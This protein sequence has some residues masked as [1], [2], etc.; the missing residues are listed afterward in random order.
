MCCLSVGIEEVHTLV[1]HNSLHIA[2]YNIFYYMHRNNST[3]VIGQVYYYRFVS[4][5]RLNTL[6][7]GCQLKIAKE[8]GPRLFYGVI[9]FVELRPTC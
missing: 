9:V 5:A 7:V 8:N 1:M 6:G 4:Y 3:K 2:Q